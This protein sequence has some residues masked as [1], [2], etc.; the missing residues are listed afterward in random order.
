MSR[1]PISADGE[2]EPDPLT[3][4]P[5]SRGNGL[6]A[7]D[8]WQ[9]SSNQYVRSHALPLLS[10]AVPGVDLRALSCPPPPGSGPDPVPGRAPDI[11]VRALRPGPGTHPSVEIPGNHRLRRPD[12]RH[13][14]FSAP[15]AA[16]GADPSGMDEEGPLRS[17]PGNGPGQSHRQSHQ[18]S[19]QDCARDADTYH[20][21]SRWRPSEARF[22]VSFESDAREPGRA[23]R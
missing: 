8:L 13:A 6:A 7:S 11:R 3:S 1:S 12:C 23:R 19:G 14:R 22:A 15:A 21:E 20:E 18:S 17:R 16:P 2:K 10:P 5:H 4:R 9:G